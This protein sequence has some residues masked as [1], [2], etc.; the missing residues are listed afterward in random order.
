M[1]LSNMGFLLYEQGY[2]PEAIA[3][4]SYAVQVRQSLHD[5]AV[6]AVIDFL[7]VLEQKMGPEAFA[8]LRS[9]PSVN[10][11]LGTHDLLSRLLNSNP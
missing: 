7:S 5:P 9:S 1:I 10:Y 3:L 8:R 2:L 6:S 11:N 4:L